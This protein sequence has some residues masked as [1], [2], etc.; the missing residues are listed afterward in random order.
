MRLFPLAA[1]AAAIGAGIA[2]GTMLGPSAGV[3]AAPSEH[4]GKTGHGEVQAAGTADAGVQAAAYPFRRPFIVPVADDW[5]TQSLVVLSAELVLPEGADAAPSRA[6]EARLRD[7]MI[8][9]LTAM[10]QEGGFTD[11]L[12]DDHAAL[13]AALTAG[14]AGL[15]RE[16]TS[17]RVSEIAKRPV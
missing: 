16:G 1:N 6:D 11:P 9:V 2:C 12:P 3:G 5:R 14:V 15:L 13:E 7:R 10:A 4:A 17:V 8:A